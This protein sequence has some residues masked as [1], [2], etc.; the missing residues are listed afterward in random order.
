MIIVSRRRNKINKKFPFRTGSA[1]ERGTL[2]CSNTKA[3][4][5]TRAVLCQPSKRNGYSRM[6]Q[7]RIHIFVNGLLKEVAGTE[8]RT[9]QDIIELRN[10]LSPADA[11]LRRNGCEPLHRSMSFGTGK[12]QAA[13]PQYQHNL[14]RN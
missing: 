5:S 9:H 13:L 1:A 6:I 7:H 8:Q 3:A 11:V 4:K 14:Q 10:E 2:P 12:K